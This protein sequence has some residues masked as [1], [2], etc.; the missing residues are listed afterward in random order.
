VVYINRGDIEFKNS[1]AL[2]MTFSNLILLTVEM[3]GRSIKEYLRDLEKRREK[4]NLSF[5]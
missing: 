3:K 1:M 2:P 4:Y 5:Y